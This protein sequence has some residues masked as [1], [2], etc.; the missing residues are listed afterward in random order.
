MKITYPLAGVADSRYFG[1][2][3]GVVGS[4]Y[5]VVAPADNI[6]LGRYDD[7]AERAA[8]VGLHTREGFVQGE[9]EIVLMVH[10]L[11]RRAI[12]PPVFPGERTAFSRF[13]I[14][15]GKKSM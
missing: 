13:K 9:F 12:G 8:V 11:W 1:M 15:T 3:R 4:D 2:R 6:A 5:L 14:Q 10:T 7:C